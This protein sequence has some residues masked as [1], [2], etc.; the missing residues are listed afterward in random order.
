MSGVQS[1]IRDFNF[2]QNYLWAPNDFAN[3]QNWVRAEMR[4][5]AL[6]RNG[7]SVLA[8]LLCAPVSGMNVSISDGVGIDSN[9][10]IVVAQSIPNVAITTPVSNPAK[11]LIVARAKLTDMTQIPTPLNPA[12]NVPLHEKLDYDIIV[13]NGTPSATPVYPTA[14]SN[15]I[16]LAGLQLP[17]GTST[18]TDAMFDYSVV[19]TPLKRR[20]ATRTITVNTTILAADDHVDSDATAGAITDTLPLAKTVPG[21][22]FTICKIDSSSN[23][24]TVA[25]TSPDL[26]SGQASWDLT[27]QWATMKVRSVGNGYRVV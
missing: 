17:T 6:A 14:Q 4:G 1:D 25:A 23:N 22:E 3:F 20:M 27:D 8:G 7:K 13:L 9:G 12:V 11:T 21:Q 15:D 5:T 16:V 2:Y 24:V 26:I 18:I 19:N 10:R